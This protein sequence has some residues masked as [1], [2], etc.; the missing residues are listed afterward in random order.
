[1]K[2]CL[3]R[4][5]KPVDSC[6]HPEQ[7]RRCQKSSVVRRRLWRF[8]SS[9]SRL[10]CKDVRK[11][12]GRLWT[13]FNMWNHMKSHLAACTID[14]N[15]EYVNVET[16]WFV[17]ATCQ[18]WNELLGPRS[19]CGNVRL[20]ELKAHEKVESL[21]NQCLTSIWRRLCE[22]NTQTGLSKWSL[23]FHFS[24]SYLQY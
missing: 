17:F 2:A 15:W 10:S 11:H 4:K 12:P 21:F 5:V 7:R 22:L 3:R 8:N 19:S 20:M 24:V 23:I 13:L 16:L 1:M 14:L 18:R 6:Q 9:G